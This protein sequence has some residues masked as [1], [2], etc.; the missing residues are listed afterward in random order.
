[1]LICFFFR[2]KLP[3]LVSKIYQTIRNVLVDRDD[4]TPR[5]RAGIVKVLEFRASRWGEVPSPDQ[6]VELVVPAAAQDN[7]PTD[8]VWYG[9]DN[10]PL[11]AE[12]AAFMNAAAKEV[13][14][15]DSD[16]DDEGG[17]A[18]QD[19][20]DPGEP[21]MVGEDYGGNEE[22]QEPPPAAMPVWRYEE[23]PAGAMDEFR[24]RL[25]P[26]YKPDAAGDRVR[27][28]FGP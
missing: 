27:T 10:V 2:Q 23:V 22:N 28:N 8:P 26:D 11:S 1:M 7:Q 6:P 20:V 24:R 19:D 17:V 12:E 21:Y 5:I 4:L 13:A 3:G 25:K 15:H 18:N 14:G 9:P 16:D